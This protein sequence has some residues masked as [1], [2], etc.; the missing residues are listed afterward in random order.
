MMKDLRGLMA[1]A[2]LMSVIIIACKKSDSQNA[3]AADGY[4]LDNP[5]CNDPEAVNYNHGFPGKPDNSICFYPTD[6]FD[7]VYTFEDQVFYSTEYI[8]S[9]EASDT[10]DITLK[11]VSRTQMQVFG[12]CK[13]GEAIKFTADKYY[14]A[15]GD[16]TFVVDSLKL[17]G[18][19]FCNNT[20]DTVTGIITRTPYSDTLTLSLAVVSD[21]GIVYHTGKAYKKQ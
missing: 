2:V 8:F 5:Y 3:S 4:N 1:F 13:G 14:R 9:P 11:P 21:T 17:P 6:V 15:V 16:S 10:F 7:G 12:I 18:Q 20:K 19:I